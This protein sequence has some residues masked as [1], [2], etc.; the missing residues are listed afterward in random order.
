MTDSPSST[1]PVLVISMGVSGCGK[2][3]LARHLAKKFGLVFLEA[4]DFHSAENK[5]HMASG[6]PLT[7]AMREPWIAA[8]CDA[9]REH[10]SRGESC[11]LAYSGLRR[12]H[13]ARFRELGY[14]VLFVHLAG[15]QEVIRRRM[16]GRVNH[17]MPADLL[18]S[19]YAA[20]EP[21]LNEPDIITVDVAQSIKQIQ[22]EAEDLVQDHIQKHAQ[23][24]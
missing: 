5:A 14:P 20:L 3:T 19:Q 22:R 17:F 23:Q 6:K 7:D 4:D 8:M 18:T 24:S 1:N 13:R 21:A 15:P 16:E 9:L 12:A 10:R 2:S 11:V